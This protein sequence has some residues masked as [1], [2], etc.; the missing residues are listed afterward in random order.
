MAEAEAE[1]E[2]AARALR[3]TETKQAASLKSEQKLAWVNP[4]SKP[5]EEEAA[6]GA[7]AR[8][9]VKVRRPRRRDQ[10]RSIPQPLQLPSRHELEAERRSPEHTN[11]EGGG[12]GQR[13]RG[14]AGEISG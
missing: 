1:A 10:R 11:C 3:P 6:A 4:Y 7:V 9:H 5:R 14:D 8:L 13:Y 2:V 12:G